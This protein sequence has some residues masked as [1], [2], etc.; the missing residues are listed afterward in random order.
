MSTVGA[1]GKRTLVTGATGFIGGW[2]VDSLVNGGEAVR[3]LVRPGTDPT[4]L[5]RKGAECVVG[6]LTDPASLARAVDGCGIVYHVAA[7]TTRRS[8]SNQDYEAVNVRGSADL[9][10]AAGRAGV[11]RLVHVSSC[12]VYGYRNRFPAD[13]EAP[14]HPDTPYRISKARG[15]RAVL[16]SARRSGLPVVVARISSIYGS[17]AKNW[18]PICRSIQEGRF[19]MIGDGKSRVH[20]AH[21]FDIVNGLRRCGETPGIEGRTYNLAAAEPIAIGELAEV[22][23][24]ALGVRMTKTVWPAFPFRVSRIVDLALCRILGLKLRRI[25]SYDL[26]LGDRW[27]DISKARSELGYSPTIATRDGM[28]A[29]VEEYRAAGMLDTP[30][31]DRAR[32]GR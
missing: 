25:H 15:E 17:G 27:F 11:R 5:A 32:S 9:A 1:A 23:A 22:I 3:A 20:L 16:E 28:P 29:L 10:T 21:V 14:L 18:V 8:V 7:V 30:S 24:A 12:G 2:L 19:R 13:E 4:R 31:I 6:D 26:F